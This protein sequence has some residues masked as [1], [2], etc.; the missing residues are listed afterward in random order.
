MGT[1]RAEDIIARIKS[2]ANPKN[3]EGMARF[4]INPTNTYGVSIPILRKMVREIGK[5]HEL[6]L[7]LWETGI[8]EARMLACFIDR[9]D[10][11]TEEQLESWV[12]NFDSWDVCDQC[13][14]NLFDR[15][16][17]AYKKAVEW[18]GREEEFVRR[19]GFVLMA[20]LAV[21]DKKAGDQAF[22][23][24]LPLIKTHSRDERNYVKKAVNWALR[25]IGKRNQNL[26]EVAIKTAEEIRQ[27]DSRSARW[28]ASDALRE[29]TGDAVQKK[30]AGVK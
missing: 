22:I 26:N 7:E 21:H 14:S 25:Q 8:H 29:L 15:T 10:M 9:P 11:V 12:K 5:D 1:A 27:M 13:C 18:C 17:L 16:G 20:C 23:E 6:A 2:L 4:G 24:F 28:I 3:V 19:A 30:L